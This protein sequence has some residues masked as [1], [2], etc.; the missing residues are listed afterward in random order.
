MS[1]PKP[2]ILGLKKSF[3]FG[4][5]LG[6]AGAGHLVAASKYAFAPILAQQSIRELNRTQRTAEEVMEVAQT[7]IQDARY[8]GNWGADA[9]HL[10]TSNDVE[11]TSRAGY[12]FFTIDPSEHVRNDADK[13]GE[14]TLRQEI[15]SQEKENLYG[16]NNTLDSLYLDRNYH[17]SDTLTLSFDTESLY[18][19]G[20]KYGRAIAHV[21]KMARWIGE[22]NPGRLTEI[23]VSVDETDTPTSSLEHL[24]FA[25]E[26]QR[27][28]VK[29]VSL[30]PRFTGDFEK[31]V[32]FKGNLQL[33]E[34]SLNEHA[35]IAK[36]M[37][38]YKLSLHSG[39]DKFTI[40]PIVGRIC[41]ELLHVKTAGT[42]YLEALRVILREDLPLFNEIARYSAGRFPVD[43]ATYKLSVTDEDVARLSHKNIDDLEDFYLNQD[44][45]RQLLHVTFGSVLTDGK[46]ANGQTFKEALL[47]NLEKHSQL[48]KQFLAAHFSKHLQLLS[49][50]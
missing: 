15:H 47:E 20:V 45:G 25:L 26:L 19:A 29:V 21:D 5:R 12:T 17:I 27:R 18:R 13:L 38:P 41:G 7:A 14:S 31:G 39:S 23:E 30:A 11:L 43:R 22:N 44:K 16:K 40:Y 9:D 49:K 48:H 36:K 37:G 24:F 34:E 3:G 50:G 33:F 2:I 10:K 46:R 28:G 4:D 8:T 1:I 6:V 32:D 42:S 35:A